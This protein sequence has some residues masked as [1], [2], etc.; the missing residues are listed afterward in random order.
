M[1]YHQGAGYGGIR[2]AYNE[3]D[4]S[5]EE[6]TFETGALSAETEVGGFVRNIIPK[7]GGNSFKGF[8]GAAYTNH[9]LES[10][11]LDDALRARGIPSANFVDKIWD[12]NPAIGGPIAQD[13]LWFY[14]AFRSWGVY[15]GIAGTY[16]NKTPTGLAYTPD[17]SHQAL[18][19]SAKGSENIRLTWMAT[20]KNKV[21]LYYEIQQ[22]HED[23]SYGQGSLGGN[24]T[25]PPEAIARYQVV[26][27]YFLQ[28]HWNH[29]VSS[30]LLLEAGA[31]YVN[32]NYSFYPQPENDPNLPAMRELSTGTVWR[33][34]PG[35]YNENRTH[36][37][38]VGSSLSYVTGSHTFKA[39][40]LFLRSDVYTT[41]GEVG[42]STV[43][44][45]LNGVPASVVVYATPLALRENL[46]AQL[47][48]FAQDHWKVKRLTLYAG[49]RF[50]YYNASI[51]V[52][53]L[54]QGPWV[55]T[56]DVSFPEVPNVP[57]WKDVTPRLGIAYDIF[58]NGKTALKATLN[59]YLFGPEL[60][61]F[62]QAVN[63]VQSI[64]TNATRTWNDANHDFIPQTSELGAL[65]ASSFG[66]PTITSH[67]APD[68]LDGWGK[69]GYNWEVSTGIDHELLPRVGISATY[70]HRWW[71]NLLVAQNQ[72]V[73]AND[74]NPYCIPAPVDSRLPGGGGNQVCGLFDVTPTKFGL[75]NNVVTFVKNFGDE[76]LVYDGID[77]SINARL[78]KGGLVGGGV[79]TGRTRDNFC[80]ASNDPSLAVTPQGFSPAGG[81]LAGGSPRTVAF[82]DIRPPFQPNT[83]L[84]G[85][86]PLPWWG[87]ETSATFQSLP[88][89]QITAS[90]TATNAL[91]APSLG[92]NL[93]AGAGG[94]ATVQLIAPGTVY[95][96]R[97]NQ[98]DFRVSKRFKVTNGP[99][100][101]AQ[102]D[103]YNLLNGNPVIAQNNTFGPAWQR[104]TVI[105]LGRLMK[106]GVQLNF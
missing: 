34:L 63:P 35:N 28:A 82:C 89:P 104:P 7:E 36:Q 76:S 51:P 31:T 72:A 74:F 79:S 53:Q 77:L 41:R 9:N 60:I 4:G 55:P 30:R 65:S 46:G 85:A 40:L 95:G 68:V 6:I 42:N 24:G 80:Y 22:N 66:L 12:V 106:F 70:I 64:A 50:D 61:S 23:Y 69:R 52:Q 25:T 54:L 58:G 5:V 48:V 105:Q 98:V 94:T 11:N 37:Y 39:G 33:N 78:R 15:Q 91:I 73:S 3:N 26:P 96:D 14:T 87:L 67:Y 8:F 83:K 29:P 27:N 16:F 59:K 56:R 75:T 20:P 101:Q 38:N 2:N 47:G 18:S 90:F 45:L 102:F 81:T 43:L 62:T 10:S 32:G 49:A 86:Y 57:N 103:L 100:V 17:L 93:A 71:G 84:Y 1:R 88:G 44:Q 19:T 13:K 21:G 99:R 97:L 92:R